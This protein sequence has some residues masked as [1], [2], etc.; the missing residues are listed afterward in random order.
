MANFW[1][2]YYSTSILSHTES[3]VILKFVVLS[4]KNVKKFKRH[5]MAIVFEKNK[6]FSFE[7]ALYKLDT[8]L[9][10]LYPSIKKKTRFR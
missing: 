4:S 1:K 9:E 2:R 6:A 10:Q 3:Y 8:I 7:V 5:F